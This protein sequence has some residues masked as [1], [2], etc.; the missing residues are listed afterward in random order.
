M[1][2]EPPFMLAINV[3]EACAMLW[4]HEAEGRTRSGICVAY[5]RERAAGDRV[6]A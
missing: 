1:A 2:G 5:G 3:Y 6:S 4:G